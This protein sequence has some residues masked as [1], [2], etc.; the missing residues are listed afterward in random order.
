MLHTLYDIERT[1]CLSYDITH[2]FI[3]NKTRK[4]CS[5]IW[6]DFLF[7]PLTHICKCLFPPCFYNRVFYISYMVFSKIF[8]SKET[9]NICE[10]SA[11]WILHKCQT[12]IEE[13]ILKSWAKYFVS[14]EFYH[15]IVR[16]LRYHISL[17]WL[18]F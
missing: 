17:F 18:C 8:I 14:K 1:F 4:F 16:V 2:H 6:Y 13:I 15:H 10:S 3:G 12:S 7:F 9:Y 5:K 11:L